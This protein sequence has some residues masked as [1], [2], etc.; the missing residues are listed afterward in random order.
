MYLGDEFWTR[1]QRSLFDIPAAK[2]AGT[3]FG[4]TEYAEAIARL[5]KTVGWR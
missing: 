4:R 5:D 1:R 2:V 3:G